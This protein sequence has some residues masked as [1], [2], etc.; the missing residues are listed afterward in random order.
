VWFYFWILNCILLINL[1]VIGWLTSMTSSW[2]FCLFVCL[3]VFEVLNTGFH[4]ISKSSTHF[5][6]ILH[7]LS[8]GFYS[9]TKHHEQKQVGEERV[10]SAYTS[11]LMFITKGSQN[12]NSSRSESRSWCRGHGRM[13]FT[14]LV[15]PG[16]LSML[17][18]RTKTTSPE[19]VSP[20]RGLSP[21]I[22]NWENVLQLDLTEAFPQM[23]L[24]SL[25]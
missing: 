12:W 17:S 20:T 18:Y 10:Y 4:E 5:L 19:M 8:Q 22:T 15:A 3:F 24:L 9:W 21:L 2:S 25:W 13:F 23:K 11:I 6:P 1:W 14:G 16:L 7:Y